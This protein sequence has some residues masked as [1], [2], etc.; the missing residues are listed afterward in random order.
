MSAGTL[1]FSQKIE[2]RFIFWQKG[3][4]GMSADERQARGIRRLLDGPPASG[5]GP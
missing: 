5:S 2:T 4:A 3:E 1:W